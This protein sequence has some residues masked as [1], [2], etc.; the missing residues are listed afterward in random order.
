MKHKQILTGLAI[1]AT[2]GGLFSV[3]HAPLPWM[4]GPLL[5]MACAKFF[6]AHVASPKGGR[7]IGQVIIGCAL[8]L[9]FTPVVALEVA[10][11]WYLLIAAAVF[12]VLLAYA[13]G[14]FLSRSTGLDGTT[15]LFASVPGGAAEMTILGERFGARSDRVVL[16]QSLRVMIVV[17][18]VPVL[19]TWLGVHGADPYSPARLDVNVA[20]LLALLAMA[21]AGGA[22]LAK[23]GVP[24]AWMLGPLA[25]AIALTVDEVGLSAIPV[26]LSNAAQL[27]LGCALGSNFESASLR[28]ASRFIVMVCISVALAILMSA[29]FAWGIALAGAVP[30]STMVL[31]TAP[32]G[33]A[34]MCVTAKVLQLG[35]PL[36]T[37]AHV[38]R[39][40]IVV[41]TTA[42]VFRI[43]KRIRSA[44]SG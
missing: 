9:Y 21:A 1:C 23:A 19:F 42:P 26:W 35:V 11:H 40:L 14:W 41:T 16:A 32:G 10:A 39:V 4:I 30:T 37:A 24:N 29:L 36:V 12:A 22:L 20:G 7:A 28:T 17:V 3:L 6:G 25:V 15:A 13:S 8:G 43:A 34:E 18:L 27:L 33:M 2:G 31:A 38:A 5:A 44:F